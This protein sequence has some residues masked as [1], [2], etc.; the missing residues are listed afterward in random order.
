MLSESYEIGPGCL[1]AEMRVSGAVTGLERVERCAILDAL[2]TTDGNQQRAAD[3]L[4]I[5]RRTLSR[6]LR[7]Y[8]TDTEEQPCLS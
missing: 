6:K 4:G 3:M 8:R 7:L 2:N 5:S 1:P